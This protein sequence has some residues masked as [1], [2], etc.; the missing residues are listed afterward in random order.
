MQRWLAPVKAEQLPIASNLTAMVSSNPGIDIC[1]LTNQSY[2]MDA[3][4]VIPSASYDKHD[5]LKRRTTKNWLNI[6]QRLLID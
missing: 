4:G 3:C 1:L 2:P 6:S 5:W